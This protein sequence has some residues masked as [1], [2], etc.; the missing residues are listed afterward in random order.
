MI[1]RQRC[2]AMVL[3]PYPSVCFRV[4][5]TGIRISW[6]SALSS[7]KYWQMV[8]FLRK[9]NASTL[10]YL[11]L[12]LITQRGDSSSFDTFLLEQSSWL[13][14][15]RLRERRKTQR[16]LIYDHTP[17]ESNCKDEKVGIK[18]MSV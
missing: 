11:A 3:W 9:W 18:M 14:S 13:V 2:R 12:A 16:R 4:P 10:I 5:G 6:L 7:K 8:I 1:L 15:L 17:F